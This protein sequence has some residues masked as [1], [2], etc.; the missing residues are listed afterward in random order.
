M[1]DMFFNGIDFDAHLKVERIRRDLLP[2]IT[3]ISTKVPTCIGNK[4]IRVEQGV[5]KI[6]VD[7]RLI[8]VNRQKV[9]DKVR[10]LAGLL[11][12]DE[13][14][15]LILRDGPT[16][17][18]LAILSDETP[19][20]KLFF[21]GFTTLVFLCLNPLAYDINST[22]ISLAASTQINNTG[23]Y[24]ATG[25]ITVNIASII[26]N[27]EVRQIETG[28]NIYIEHTF[29]AGDVVVIDLEDETVKKNGN[30][31]MTDVHLTS[32]FFVIPRALST[33]TLS[34]GSG[35]L[36]YRRRWL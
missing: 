2:P 18:N 17:Y 10:M 27:L 29:A 32:D 23:T 9:Q 6:E 16:K 33:I 24:E 31:I 25:T 3:I 1:A 20:E 4:F 21:T 12:T 35:T 14:K 19:V 22:T 30:L 11:H 8:E 34:S 7:I 13:P 15:K 26:S 36:E 28:E 5:G